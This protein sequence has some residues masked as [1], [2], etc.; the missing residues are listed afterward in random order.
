MITAWL[1]QESD[2]AAGRYQ[3]MVASWQL[4]FHNAISS[5]GFHV[6]DMPARVVNEAYRVADAYLADERDMIA[7]VLRETALEAHR[8]ILSQIASSDAQELTPMTLEHLS[9]T[10]S[11]LTDELIAQIHR[12]IAMLRFALHQAVLQVA[13]RSRSAGITPRQAQVEYRLDQQPT[14]EF[15]FTDRAGRRWNAKRFVRTV[16]RQAML[17]AYN[18]TVLFD[19]ADHGLETAAVVN[20]QGLVTTISLR[21]YAQIRDEHFHPNSNAW[22][23]MEAQ[24][25]PA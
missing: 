24:H 4:L 22:L 18:E 13:V 9:V 12:D 14:I 5:T 6:A 8:S 21:D 23:A 19:L 17:S 3:N 11:Y 1:D 16:W 15:M 25:V 20:D 10:G 7:S 2:R